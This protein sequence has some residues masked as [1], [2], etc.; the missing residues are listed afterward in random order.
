MVGTA[1]NMRVLGGGRRRIRHCEACFHTGSHLR[2]WQWRDHPHSTFMKED[3]SQSSKGIQNKMF[4]DQVL[5]EISVGG[6]M[7]MHIVQ[8]QVENGYQECFVEI[9][10]DFL[11]PFMND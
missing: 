5:S 4:P 6:E 1:V 10:P 11:C 9:T 3:S 8:K 7:F 2:S